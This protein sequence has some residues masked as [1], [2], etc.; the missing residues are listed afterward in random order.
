MIIASRKRL[1]KSALH[2]TQARGFSFDRPPCV[3]FAGEE[4]E[5]EGGPSREF[6]K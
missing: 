3:T 4:A 5:D 6:F 1:L 2:A